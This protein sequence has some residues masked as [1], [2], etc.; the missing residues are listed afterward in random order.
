MGQEVWIV[1]VEGEN[2]RLMSNQEGGDDS[3]PVFFWE[4]SSTCK[5]I[6]NNV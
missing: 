4:V 1:D 5:C 3:V 2:V 6:L